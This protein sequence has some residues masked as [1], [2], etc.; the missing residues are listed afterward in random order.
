M[1]VTYFPFDDQFCKMIF[2][3]WAY[4]GAHVNI[5]ETGAA[6]DLANYSPSG[7]FQLLSELKTKS[8]IILK[9]YKIRFDRMHLQ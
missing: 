3:S 7:E 1:D 9:S 5:S 8:K 2:A 4:H 6:G